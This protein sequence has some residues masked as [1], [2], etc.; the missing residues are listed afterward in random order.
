MRPPFLSQ[1]VWVAGFLIMASFGNPLLAQVCTGNL[2]N[3]ILTDGDFG[4]GTANILPVDPGLAPGYT[5]QV[6]PPPD[7]G[8]YNITNNTSTWGSF[9]NIWIDIGDNSPDPNGYM[10]VVNANIQPDIFFERTVDVC[11]NTLY[12]FSADIINL[13][14]PSQ[15]GFILPNMDFE[16]NGQV[17]FSTGD[18]PQNGQWN[19]VGFT[20]ISDPGATQIT[21]TLRNNAPGGN[22]ND[23]ALDNISFRPC[24]PSS[25]IDA[26]AFCPG[27]TGS[28]YA[29]IDDTGG[30]T[31]QVVQWQ[32]SVNGGITWINL[33]G[34]NEL[35][36]VLT[37]PP[38]GLQY[39]YLMASS[40]GNLFQ[41]NCR[42]ISEVHTISFTPPPTTVLNE[43]ICEGESFT[44]NSN[45]YTQEGFYS[46]TLITPLG[47]DSIVEL[48]LTVNPP[49][50]SDIT[51]TIC[52]G[53]SV[54]LGSN[55][56][57]TSGTYTETFTS[58]AGCDS[59]VTL[60]LIV[61]ENVETNLTETICEGESYTLGV[62]TYTTAGTYM[63]TF[64][65]ANGCD[66][67]VNVVL[68]VD[69]P[70]TTDLSESICEG[71][72]VTLGSNTYSTAGTYTE[73]FT[74]AAGCDSIV[75][76]VLTVDPPITT[77][78]SES[79]CEGESV[80]LGSNTYS[81]AG[82][83]TETFTS[84]AGCD[85][86]VTLVL[87]VDPPI[88]TDLNES[89][90]EG[91]SV[92]LGSNT[93]STAGTYTETFTSTAGCDST[94][95]LVLTVD[96][97]ITT[98]L[99]ESICE[100]E[101]V[102]L[103]SNTYSTAGTYTE[104]FTSTAG[105]DSTVTLVLTVD[106]E[107]T[108][109]ISESICEGESVTLGSN[110]YSTAGTYTETFTSAAGC[111]STVTLV[112]TVDPEIT[113]DISE[114]IC[115]GESVT[116]GSNTYSTAGTYTETF[117]SAAGCDST[118]TLV[119]TVDPEITTDISESICEGG[120]VTLGSNTYST[121]GTYTETF[122][123]AAGCDS[124][125]TLVLTVD[126]EITT[127]ISESI[128]EGGSVTLGSNTYSTAG[129]YTETFTSAAGCDSTVTL[130]LTV[131]DIITTDLQESI[132][133]GESYSIGNST[134]SQT[135]IY[136]ENLTTIAG[137]DSIVTLDLTVN[138]IIEVALSEA[139]CQGQSV[140]IGST[141]YDQTGIYT[142]TLVSTTGCD[143]I[144]TLDLQ[145]DDFIE[146][147]LQIGICEGETYTVGT[148]TYDQSGIYTETLT[149]AAGCDSIVT[150]DLTI[151][152]FISVDLESTIC[153][154][155]TVT[156]GSSV[157]SE[158]G[159]YTETLM[160]S[161]GC[162]SIVTLNLT[163]NEVLNTALQEEICSGASI[164][165]G[166][167]VYTQSGTYTDVLTSSA[168]C[169]S[170]VTLDLMVNDAIQVALSESICP[171]QSVT[172]GSSTYS[173][174]GTY[175][176]TLTSS[177]GCDSIITLDLT[178]SD[179]IEVSLVES[180]CEGQT[181]TIGN[182]TY[183]TTGLYT[184]T[185]TSSAGCDSIITLDLTVSDAIEVSMVESVCE[186]QTVTIGNSTYGTTGLYTETLTSSA[187]CDS[188]ITLDL[189]V[190]DAIEVS[191]VE[192]VCEGQTV[193]IGNSTYGMTGLYT[194]T[195]TSS[196]GCDSIITLDLTV[197][198]A[199][200]VSLVESVCEGQTVTIGNS[201]Y[202]TT[203]LYTETLTSSAG[204]DSIITLDLTVSDAIEVSLV[205][206]VCEGQTVTIGNS[207]YG[208]TG[209]YTETLIS[210]AGCDS[211]ITSR[212]DGQ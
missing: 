132:C 210:S 165:V 153:A 160:S 143:S 139:I 74:S 67:M 11:E 28:L 156:V 41:P 121:A 205:E 174:P 134:Y 58:A 72:S 20:F 104:T 21:L 135:G 22:G 60:V 200:E 159:T 123:S 56:Y 181:V 5:Y 164:M 29:I 130:V 16:I 80:T 84:A 34:E 133:E 4:S 95:T 149:S 33:V 163:V 177:A 97:P 112:L 27:S 140:T 40:S 212:F 55:T 57:S 184:E 9:A 178:V 166:N 64:P 122:T 77:D 30:T 138:E 117:T 43:S 12:E 59:T 162:D 198:D 23:L 102:T 62:D 211:I 114:S 199:I 2:G 13:V 17:L 88:T 91:E 87:T 169:D 19:T 173:T 100:G 79:I 141:S 107:I 192:S 1:L 73:T 208:M 94:V 126:P 204:C 155:E 63:A 109:D 157:Y 191:L 45:V 183:G 49:V 207:T 10:M 142:E 106:P 196:A 150:L 96:P 194:E 136:T 101:S 185:L 89:I 116:L 195:L 201:T 81:I 76:L 202:G 51:E 82:T 53:A 137:C 197:S 186:G 103:G 90:C 209:L 176:E 24:G 175:T 187:G 171:G 193:T 110:T 206:S 147:A 75:T 54:T 92:T 37:N 182:S 105:C 161:A 131:N 68:T 42:I 148:S 154:G 158:T 66:S 7:D 18:V 113:T 152:D 38:Q 44:L 190:S 98:D 168:G 65:G 93:Y 70:I 172:V 47:C 25:T 71:E 128:C 124:T 203:G 129:T 188:I 86:I 3:N 36:L 119:L 115:E 167:S 35:E 170:I 78:L 146:V 151:S 8:F 179:A 99:N 125:V 127:D 111:D 61:N 144:V 85:S 145:V 15:P 39:R 14:E 180:V 108:T 189:T 83:Y 31:N 52:E 50:T 48:N 118:V 46:E 6:N 32:I 69:P 26:T 120:S